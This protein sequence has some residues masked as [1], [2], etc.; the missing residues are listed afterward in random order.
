MSLR[1]VWTSEYNVNDITSSRHMP[2]FKQ[3]DVSVLM[4][5]HTP[6][7]TYWNDLDLCSS[8]SGTSIRGLNQKYKGSVY[9]RL[10][11]G[12]EFAVVIVPRG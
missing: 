1:S 2:L 3:R 10:Q 9:S 6:L 8:C 11:F 5:I 4:G 12:S 7:S